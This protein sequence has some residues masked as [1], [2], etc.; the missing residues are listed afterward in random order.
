MEVISLNIV[1][2]PSDLDKRDLII[3]AALKEFGA[4]SFDKASTNNIVKNAGVSKGLLYH[5]FKSKKE[6]YDYLTDFIYQTI[7]DEIREKCDFNEG[8]FFKRIQNVAMIKINLT[9][10]YPGLYDFGMK[11]IKDYSYEE[12]LAKSKEY[13]F[14]LFQKIYYE[15][16][17]VSLFKESV[18]VK[19]AMTI[20]QW[21]IEKFGETFENR[22]IVD[23]NSVIDEMNMYLNPLKDAFYK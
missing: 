5:Y 10:R 20:I 1:F 8:D 6:L 23:Y 15:N 13:N 7:G 16:I 3:N 19:V 17:D 2:K 18:D 12:L 14:E 22:T 11:L 21:T 4:N 9:N